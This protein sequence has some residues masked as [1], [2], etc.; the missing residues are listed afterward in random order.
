MDNE[1]KELASRH[2]WLGQKER[3]VIYAIDRSLFGA[4][5]F[6]TILHWLFHKSYT[7]TW[8]YFPY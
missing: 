4:A 3:R 8:G 1:T 6:Y 7:D 2:Y 5:L